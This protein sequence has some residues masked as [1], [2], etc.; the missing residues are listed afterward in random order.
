MGV[1]EDTREVT[2]GYGIFDRI[3][4]ATAYIAFGLLIFS[5]FSVCAEVVFRYFLRQPIIWVVEVTEYIMVQITF[6]GSAW[7]LRK[8][9]HVTVDVVTSRLN[10]KNRTLFLMITSVIGFVIFLIITWWGIVATWGA[11]QE[12]LYIPKQLEMPKFLVMLVIP[13]GSFMLAGQFLRRTLSA[14][15]TWRSL[16]RKNKN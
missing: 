3:I 14:V 7:L 5:W 13:F 10:E 16:R 12:H 8:E 2:K 4:D 9:G 1:V 15:S 6:V 11:Y